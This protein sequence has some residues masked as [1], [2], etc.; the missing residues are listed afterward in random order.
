MNFKTRLLACAGLLALSGCQTLTE[1]ADALPPLTPQE[2]CDASGGRWLFVTTY[3]ANG[4]P[5]QSG[6]CITK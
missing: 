6:E 5:T 1:I 4:V 2:Q 3:D